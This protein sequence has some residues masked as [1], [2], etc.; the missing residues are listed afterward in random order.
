MSK[1][2]IK[3]ASVLSFEKKLVPSDAFFYGT[4]WE[5][6]HQASKA[7]ELIEKSVRGTIS[8]RLKPADAKD[9]L[10][11]NAKVENANLQRVDACALG[12]HE[13]TL[14][15]SFTLKVLSGLENPSACNDQA[16]F[17]T[18]RTTV[19]N[20]SKEFGFKELAKRYAYNIANARFLWRNRVGA[21]KIEVVVAINNQETLT[22]DAH[23]YSLKNFDE[24]DANLEK[25]AGHIANA[26]AGE[27]AYLLIKV[28]AYTLVGNAQEVYPSEELVLDKNDSNKD[29][30]SKILYSVNDVAAMH[31]QKVGNALRTIDTWYP[32]F[33]EHQSPIAIEPYGSVTNLGRAFRTPKEKNDFFTLFDKYATGNDL[34]NVEQKHYVIAVLIRGGVFG[35]SS[36]E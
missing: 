31:S 16:F 27:T 20:Y 29:K 25:L 8:N 12:E 14:K 17:E 22:F 10:K 18:Y 4:N 15:V 36:K 21:E 34:D 26:L 9:P 24:S 7:L 2:S 13:D 11:I 33:I 1:N 6:R 5:Q 23:K 32:D 35:Q 3:V 19:Q 28:D 30:K